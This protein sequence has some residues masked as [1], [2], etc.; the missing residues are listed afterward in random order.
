MHI[1]V[2]NT[3][4]VRHLSTKQQIKTNIMKTLN[5]TLPEQHKKKTVFIN[6]TNT[7]RIQWDRFRRYGLN[8]S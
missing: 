7:K 5:V 1:S 3:N 4:Y 8:A 2:T 6:F